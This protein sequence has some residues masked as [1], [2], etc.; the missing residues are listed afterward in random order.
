MFLETPRFPDTISYG[1]SGGP[2]YSTEVLEMASGATKRNV[3]WDV[4]KMVW[5]V[6]TGVNSLEDAQALI[7][8]FRAVRGSG[9]AFRFK[10]HT[11]YAVAYTEGVMQ[12]ISDDNLTFQLYKLYSLGGVER[13]IL[14]PVT[15]TGIKNNG[16]V[17]SPDD[18]TIDYTTGQVV[19]DTAKTEA[20]LGWEG[21]F[22][23]P[24]RFGKDVMNLSLV[25]YRRFEWSSIEVVE[26][27]HLE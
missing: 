22:D 24:C 9:Y 27:T 3:N 15:V 4:G 26:E 6:A 16:V 7:A 12:S 25:T 20:N 10:D 18:Y 14:K 21:T 17:V 11:D 13:R 2:T 5:N 23:V 8:F 1:A 19:F